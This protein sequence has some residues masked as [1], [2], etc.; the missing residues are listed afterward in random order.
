MSTQAPRLALSITD[1]TEA[2]AAAAALATAGFDVGGPGAPST[3]AVADRQIEDGSP[4]VRS[5]WALVAHPRAPVL[6]LTLAEA[7][8]ILD[9]TTADWSDIVPSDEPRPLALIVPAA[10]QAWLLRAAPSPNSFLEVASVEW[11]PVASD[12]GRTI[13][14]RSWDASDRLAP[15][16]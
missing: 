12:E 16:E 1:P 14:E 15:A 3:F 11:V 6:D 9:G 10:A 5:S 8:A 4:Y 2:A 7:T 13:L